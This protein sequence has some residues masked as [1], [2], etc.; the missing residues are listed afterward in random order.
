MSAN[1]NPDPLVADEIDPI[2]T[3]FGVN[4]RE[5]IARLECMGMPEHSESGV[6]ISEDGKMYSLRGIR[7]DT[8]GETVWL[9][10][11]EF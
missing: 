6:M 2:D 11:E 10:I 3:R 7:Y 9:E 4:L 5:L 1:P 8:E